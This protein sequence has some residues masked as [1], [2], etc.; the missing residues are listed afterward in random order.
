MSATIFCTPSVNLGGQS[1]QK[2]NF[3]FTLVELLVVIAIIGMLIALLLPAVQAAREAARRMQCLNHLKQ[4]ALAM[5]NHHDVHNA[6]PPLGSMGSE[7]NATT[8]Q[9]SGD[10]LSWTVW[11]LRYMEQTAL[12]E[13]MGEQTVPT[14]AQWRQVQNGQT[15]P[16]VAGREYATF[17]AQPWNADWTPNGA[18]MSVR[19]CPSDTRRG[20]E[21]TIGFLSYRVNVGD[22]NS[23]WTSTDQIYPWMIWRGLF[24]HG[25]DKG[26]D[27]GYI[28]D[29]LSNTLMLG[30]RRIGSGEN[31]RRDLAD[32]AHSNINSG[33]PQVCFNTF[34]NATRAFKNTQATQGTA[35]RRW[36]DSLP[37]YSAFNAFLPP[38]G[39]SC[40]MYCNGDH[41]TDDARDSIITLSSAH[42]GGVNVAMADCGARFL[43]DTVNTAGLTQNI[44]DQAIVRMPSPYGVLGALST[45]NGGESVALP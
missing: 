34:D 31:D 28:D 1:R 33:Q 20:E 42:T 40:F 17:G 4:W 11:V 22:Y 9:L 27:F 45:A 3:A 41:S 10:R 39:P 35:G 15:G 8:R 29:G 16:T 24:I 25:H 19:L 5:H 36:A 13:A 14:S 26:R 18:K 21:T 12:Y 7:R 23:S 44:W 2:R 37:A 30:E 6:L 43:S 38:N 32:I